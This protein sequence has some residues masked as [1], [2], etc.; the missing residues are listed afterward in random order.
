MPEVARCRV[1]KRGLKKVEDIFEYISEKKIRAGYGRQSF[2]DIAKKVLATYIV[3]SE[4]LYIGAKTESDLNE[5][6][7]QTGFDLD[8]L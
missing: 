3:L 2:I 8:W 5:F 4:D 1:P 6:E 7:K